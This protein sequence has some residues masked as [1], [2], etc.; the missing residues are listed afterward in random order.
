MHNEV[1]GLA[2]EAGQWY[3]QEYNCLM[4]LSNA[5]ATEILDQ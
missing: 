1:K 3:H 2:Q 5:P 4:P